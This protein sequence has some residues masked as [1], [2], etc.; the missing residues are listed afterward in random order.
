MRKNHLS[1]LSNSWI[2]PRLLTLC[3]RKSSSFQSR[4]VYTWW[5]KTFSNYL[6][7][8]DDSVHEIIPC[9]DAI[10]VKHMVEYIYFEKIISSESEINYYIVL[11]LA[12]KYN[13]STLMD[14]CT[15]QIIEK[16]NFN[17]LVLTLV[18]GN[19]L[20]LRGIKESALRFAARNSDGITNVDNWGLL[21]RNYGSIANFLL[22]IFIVVLLIMYTPC[23]SEGCDRSDTSHKKWFGHF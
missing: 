14:F 23:F 18:L 17:N 2:D 5:N 6:Y 19:L 16:I 11:K 22:L 4:H 10:S 12:H 21:L 13:I 1:H 20:G 9:I 8:L 3:F 15:A 7:L